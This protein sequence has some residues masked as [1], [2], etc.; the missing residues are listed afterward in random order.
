M[1]LRDLERDIA[2]AEASLVANSKRSE[3][4]PAQGTARL[5]A[6]VEVSASVLEIKRQAI[7]EDTSRRAE[8]DRSLA[9]SR[10]LLK[11]IEAKLAELAGLGADA[12]VDLFDLDEAEE[13]VKE[14]ELRVEARRAEAKAALRSAEM[15][16]ARVQ[17]LSREP[18]ITRCPNC[19][20]DLAGAMAPIIDEA[21]RQHEEAEVLY[22]R[23]D[24]AVSTALAMAA[25]E[26][27]G[28]EALRA[29][30]KFAEAREEKDRLVRACESINAVLGEVPTDNAEVAVWH[31]AQNNLEE[32]IKA[33]AMKAAVADAETRIAKLRERR[34][35]IPPTRA[36]AEVDAE[37]RATEAEFEAAGKQ[38]GWVDAQATRLA[39]LAEARSDLESA[40]KLCSDVKAFATELLES[41]RSKLEAPLTEAVGARVEL[42]TEDARGNAT[43][44]LTVDG[45]DIASISTGERLRFIGAMLPVLG[46]QSGAEWKPVIVDG[47]ESVSI[48]HRATFLRQ[49]VMAV[50]EGAISQAFVMTCDER[51]EAVEGVRVTNL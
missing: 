11:S 13:R 17:A 27:L 18:P 7:R 15:S 10:K 49:L 26:T 21:M 22:A 23:A 43:C 4:A 33:E 8:A 31:R 5:R 41:V 29:R 1:A 39:E 35:E 40:S 3:G 28:L 16:A 47:F 14:A 45:V 51:T 34:D 30:V 38:A 19:A 9:A 46:R 36:H 6:D 48:E 44:R 32:A 50:E 42:L 20:H 25:N 12:P 2:D 37:I 24:E